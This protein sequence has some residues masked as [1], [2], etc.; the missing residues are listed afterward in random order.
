MPKTEAE[1]YCPFCPAGFS[2]KFFEV[3]AE[4]Y[5]HFQEKH[6]D[7][8]SAWWKSIHPSLYADFDLMFEEYYDNVILEDKGNRIEPETEEEIIGQS[9]STVGVCDCHNRSTVEEMHKYVEALE[10]KVEELEKANKAMRDWNQ[11]L[12]KEIGQFSEE[13]EDDVRERMADM[14]QARREI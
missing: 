7:N 1:I 12:L 3:E 4:V 6:Q 2:G 10:Q 14:A 5:C 8:L 9:E 13:N 11:R